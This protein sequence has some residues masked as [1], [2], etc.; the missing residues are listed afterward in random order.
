MFKTIVHF[1]FVLSQISLIL[2][3]SLEK[4]INIYKQT[5]INAL[6]RHYGEFN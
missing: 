2:T 6:A 5:Q 4:Y 1:S 3:K